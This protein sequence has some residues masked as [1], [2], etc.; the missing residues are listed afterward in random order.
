MHDSKRI[1]AVIPARGGSVSV[2]RKNIQ[3]LGGEPL[4]VHTLRQAQKV[5]E[6]DLFVV[7][8]DSAEI[9]QVACEHGVTVIDR[10]SAL[11]SDT[12]STE[13]ALLHALDAL[14]TRG[15]KSFDYVVVMEPTSPFRMPETI[16]K[17]IRR[18]IES[19]EDS[20]MTVRETRDN[21]GTICNSVF[22]PLHSD[23]PRRRQ[24]REPFYVESSTVYVCRVAYLRQTGTLVSQS[25]MAEIVAGEE[26]IDINTPVDL[27]IADAIMRARNHKLK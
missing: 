15:N 8:T 13:T 5:P 27:Q 11:A 25:W 12:A 23:A 18:L 16:S 1:L 19:G 26:T 22:Q 14:E 17:C 2:P 10:P 9:K 6:L 4:L 3:P 7:S 20:L 24:E 21:I